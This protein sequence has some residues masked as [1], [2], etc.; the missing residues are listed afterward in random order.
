MVEQ[1]GAA[2]A[3]DQLLA[4]DLADTDLRAAVAAR[5]R[6]VDVRRAADIALR[7]A[8][9]SGIRL[10]TP[11]DTEWPAPIDDLA[12]ARAPASAARVRDTMPPL[13]LWVRG[14]GS[15]G[16]A[17]TRSVAIVGARAASSYGV[18]VSSSFASGLAERGWTVTSGGA[19]GIDAAAHRGAMG[20]DG[21]RTVAVLACGLDRPYPAANLALFDRIAERGLLVS[22]WPTG[23]EPLRHRFLLRNRI[24]AAV[25]AGTVV[26]EAAPRSG[27][28][29]MLGRALELKRPAM[30]VPGPVTSVLS[31]GGHDMLR[32]YPAARPVTSVDDILEEINRPDSEI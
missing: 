11:S 29:Q 15:L 14:A 13:C 16:D 9:R 5:T 26:V 28:I 18:H 25:T 31:Q 4:G 27:T 6:M 30:I 23:F 21:S 17:C 1:T 24:V 8:D 3:L 22:E 32:R 7:H 12:T 20:A 10:V 19:Y 2:N